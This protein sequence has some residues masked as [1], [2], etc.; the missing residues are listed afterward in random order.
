MRVSTSQIYA[1]GTRSI[2]D[3]QSALYKTQ[4]QLGTERR[5]LSP[6]DD[7]VA[8]AQI[9]LDTQARNVV[10]QYHDNQSNAN[11]Q[12]ALEES[13]IQSVVDALQ[14][15]RAQVIAGGNASYTDS[16]RDYI[17]K[18][19]QSQFD[20]LLGVANSQDAS[21]QYLFSGFQGQTQ[22]FQLQADGSVNY[23][24]DTGQRL[25]QVSASRQIPVSDTGYAVFLNN[26][27]GNGTFATTGATTNTGSGVIGSGT[28]SSPQAW[29]GGDYQLQFTDAE[30]FD[31]IQPSPLPPIMGLSY[32]PGAA[33]T[34]IP[35]A[36]FT[37]TG[38][39][40]A[41]DSFDIK[42][43]TNQSMFDTLQ[44]L[45]TA[46]SSA[47]TGNPAATATAWNGIN[48]GLENLDQVLTTVAAMQASIGSRMNE[49]SALSS[50]ASDTDLN[51]QEK[52][53]KL[54][55]IDLAET[56][57]RFSNQ[58]VQL[59]AAQMSFAKISGLS[60]FNYI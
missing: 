38:T 28:V 13:Q 23:L 1:L 24:G 31:L 8:S 9:L 60:L 2:M 5:I 36:S 4:N 15:I 41:G 59:Q 32:V 34:A 43:S 12:L 54:Q 6:K 46:F 21:G 33:I 55:D 11:T 18:D 17:A 57:S 22:P 40:A 14:H 29:P 45:I 49:L 7:P 27:S 35:G 19:L 50:A 30:H 26:R 48:A 37:I 3:G 56:I 44:G 53:S 39:P 25:M 52:I 10:S 47:T 20:H 42:S 51:Y 16:Q 58:Q